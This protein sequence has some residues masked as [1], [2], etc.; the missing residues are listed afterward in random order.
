[1]FPA[2]SSGQ[3]AGT[4]EGKA[5]PRITG[6][7]IRLICPSMKSQQE[8][9]TANHQRCHDPP[10]ADRATAATGG[11]GNCVC[12][13]RCFQPCVEDI[14]GRNGLVGSLIVIKRN[15]HAGRFKNFVIHNNLPFG[16]GGLWQTPLLTGCRT[17]RR[18]SSPTTAKDFSLCWANSQKK[19]SACWGR[20]T[21][22]ELCGF[23][24]IGLV[25]CQ[26]HPREENFGGGAQN[27]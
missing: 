1:M 10:P 23:T 13:P 25:S 22:A 24:A 15:C 2:I 16:I 14:D 26:F 12:W 19:A 7:G 4:S 9:S 18:T 8:P 21:L 27:S 20:H 6:A 5:L 11:H 17:A 3:A